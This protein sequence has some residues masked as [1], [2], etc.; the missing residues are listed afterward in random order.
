MPCIYALCKAYRE[1]LASDQ[2]FF[3]LRV[4]RFTRVLLCWRR[5]YTGCRRETL[6]TFVVRE[7]VAA[8]PVSPS[9]LVNLRGTD[10][11]WLFSL[12]LSLSFS[13][14]FPT[15]SPRFFILLLF[16]SLS[17]FSSLPLFFSSPLISPPFPFS[18]FLPFLRFFSSTINLSY[19]LFSCLHV[20]RTYARTHV[21]TYLHTFMHARAYTH[22]H[23]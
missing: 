4:C 2:R 20:T 21:R 5:D 16:F 8:L 18:F 3:L 11:C 13:L 19:L 23:T 7:G 9:V 6:V 1:C 14:L 12:S 10:H 15:S 22:L 17:L